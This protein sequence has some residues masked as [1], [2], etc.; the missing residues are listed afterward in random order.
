MIC[1]TGPGHLVAVCKVSTVKSWIKKEN[2]KHSLQGKPIKNVITM[3]WIQDSNLPLSSNNYYVRVTARI[4]LQ[5]SHRADLV[6]LKNLWYGCAVPWLWWCRVWWLLSD[7]CYVI[8]WFSRF[9]QCLDHHAVCCNF[10]C[11]CELCS[12]QFLCISRTSQQ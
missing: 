6:W 4:S 12:T 1:I 9:P 3:K 5:L 2:C 8:A 11:S 7:M 10:S